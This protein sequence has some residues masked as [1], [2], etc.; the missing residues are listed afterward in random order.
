MTKGPVETL[1]NKYGQQHLLKFWDDLS[2]EQQI[3][4]SE[5]LLS[6][7]F[8]CVKKLSDKALEDLKNGAVNKDQLIEPLPE[9]LVSR[10]STSSPEQKEEWYNEGLKQISEGTVAVLL[11]A[12]GQG[13]RLGVTYPKGMYDVGLPSGKTLYQ[14]QAERI[15]K[16]QQLASDKFSSRAVIKWYVMTSDA[17]LK[18]T[19]KFFEENSYFGLDKKNVIFF[20]QYLL[21]CLTFEGKM[22]LQNK[23]SL[24]QA[25][26]GNGGLYR[27]LKATNMLDSFESN[28]IKHVYVYCVDNIL[29][30]IADPLFVGFC[31]KNNLECGNKV[32]EKVDPNEAV[33]VVCK[34]Q[35]RFEVVEYSEISPAV[36]EKRKPDGS[37][38]YNASNICIHYFSTEF[39]NKV[40]NNHLDE[41]P[42]H[43]AKKKIPH[44]NEAGQLVK[45]TTP[46]GMKLEKFVFDVF[47]FSSRFAVLEC[48]RHQEF[49]PLKNGP[50]SQKCS[51]H[52]CKADLLYLH[53]TYLK[54]AGATFFNEDGL[55]LEERLA[56]CEISPYLSY[57]GEGLDGYNGEKFNLGKAVN[58]D[59]GLEQGGGPPASKKSKKRVLGVN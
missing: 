33:G 46:N 45:P 16:V 58:L 41:L 12:G 55:T 51:P 6:I 48:E 23:W 30:K 35:N 22:M 20:E 10:L 25:P 39:L 38:F 1:L 15:L 21:P 53:Y 57:A 36:A 52:S 42:H 34:C 31:A 19:R 56:S 43:I 29:V 8:E 37:L 32:I 49:S 4:F 47:P 9:K 7:D 18:E 54:N 24:A 59:G 2:P 3:S 17:T 5:E 26:D 13:T 44:L 11:L 14:L 40:C 28:G 50:D 27:A